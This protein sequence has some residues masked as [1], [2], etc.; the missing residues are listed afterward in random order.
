VQ[1]PRMRLELLSGGDGC[2]K[3]GKGA[4]FNCTRGLLVPFV[5]PMV[6]YFLFR[7]PH[8]CCNYTLIS[9]G[10]GEWLPFYSC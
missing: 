7:P 1:G 3:V 5:E 4:M 9:R 6:T 10:F 8:V 2:R